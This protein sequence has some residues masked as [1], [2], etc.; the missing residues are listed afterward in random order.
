MAGV[1][2]VDALS[3]IS[4]QAINVE[5]SRIL[6]HQMIRINFTYMDYTLVMDR[7]VHSTSCSCENNRKGGHDFLIN[8]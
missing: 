7:I 2:I 1:C 4:L 5:F 6:H 8:N 3:V